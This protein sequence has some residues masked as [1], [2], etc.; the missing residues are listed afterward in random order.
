M[1]TLLRPNIGILMDERP[2]SAV[3]DQIRATTLEV[4]G[5]KAIDNTR[6]HR[7]GSTYTIDMEIA[8]DSRLTVE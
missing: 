3:L 6:V 4:G 2:S 7:R 5:I 8:V 1:L